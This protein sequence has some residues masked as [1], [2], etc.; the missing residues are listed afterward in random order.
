MKPTDQSRLPTETDWIARLIPTSTAT[1]AGW[2]MRACMV[3]LAKGFTGAVRSGRRTH[4]GRQIQ[5]VI[6]PNE[7]RAIRRD[8]YTS[9]A[10]LADHPKREHTV[11]IK[12]YAPGEYEPM[13]ATGWD[14]ETVYGPLGTQYFDGDCLDALQA[15][16]TP[17]IKTSLAATTE[18]PTITT[19][20]TV[21]A[22]GR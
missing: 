17:K 9:Q 3:L 4:A 18:K 13:P 22:S 15:V 7:Y 5:A 19:D 10:W 21:R 8:Q 1:Q 16:G 20:P 12:R 14:V 6:R 11:T 2:P